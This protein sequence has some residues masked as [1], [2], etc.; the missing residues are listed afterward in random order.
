LKYCPNAGCP[1]ALR[2][3]ESQEYRDDAVTCSDCGATLTA[4]RL[5]WPAAAA[6]LR[7]LHW[8]KVAL[9]LVLPLLIVWLASRLPMPRIDEA[10]FERRLGA[11]GRTMMVFE[12]GLGPFMSAFFF[13]ELF[14]LCIPRW[15][16]LRHGGPPGRGRLLD[17][18]AWLGVTFSAIQ[19]IS[20]A[21][22]LGRMGLLEKNV[23]LSLLIVA[24]TLTAG[25]CVLFLLTEVLD[26][27]ALGGGFAI[28]TTAFGAASAF[29][30]L[31]ILK[32]DALGLLTIILICTATVVVLKWRPAHGLPLPACGVVPLWCSSVVIS[33]A[34]MLAAFGIWTE[35]LR[36]FAAGMRADAWFLAI[37]AAAAVGFG[38]LFNRPSKI[39]AFGPDA[40]GRVARAVAM[41]TAFILGLGIL[42]WILGHRID[43]DCSGARCVEFSLIPIAVTAALLDVIAEAR[44]IQQHGELVSVWPE[45]RL[46]AVAGAVAVLARS[47]IPAFP[48][49]A[50]Q[51]A[52][53]H[54]FA[55]FI[56]IK[57][58]VPR[59]QAEEAEMMLQEH[60]LARQ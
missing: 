59:A 28:L 54:F 18:A 30:L 24:L 43:V 34:L 23:R 38:F 46:S 22:Y 10:G 41:S 1:Y 40:P 20:V 19:A 48:R 2:H 9:T 57:I 39:T 7:D 37:T 32:Q 53:W 6:N 16:L 8:G 17:A 49:S 44:A 4:E 51:R 56:P 14:A 31:R 52:L 11:L 15:R 29:P 3:R 58:M 21:V 5:V 42:G 47:G 13:V 35:P 60:H 25:T 27:A 26:R 45:H 50:N 55:P 36:A 12:L 33:G